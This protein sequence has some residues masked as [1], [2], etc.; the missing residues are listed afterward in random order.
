MPRVE[1]PSLRERQKVTFQGPVTLAVGPQAPA[2]FCDPGGAGGENTGGLEDTPFSKSSCL[3]SL[4]LPPPS[5][6]QASHPIPQIRVPGPERPALNPAGEWRAGLSHTPS[7]QNVFGGVCGGGGVG[8]LY[9]KCF[10]LGL[11]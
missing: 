4:G 8:V 7:P 9:P 11:S 5:P 10:V 6:V 1:K 3:C 2:L